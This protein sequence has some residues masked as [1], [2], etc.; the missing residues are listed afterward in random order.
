LPQ[1]ALLE[2]N[3]V[4]FL[5]PIALGTEPLGVAAISVTSVSVRSELLAE[6]RE[7]L[8]IVLKVAKDRHG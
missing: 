7:L 1:H 4:L 5:L 8:T 3:R 2:H 6:L